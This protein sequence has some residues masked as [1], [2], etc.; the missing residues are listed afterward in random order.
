MTK[1]FRAATCFAVLLAVTAGGCRKKTPLIEDTQ[2]PVPK[3]ETTFTEPE[4]F[5]SIDTSDD[6]SF[7]EADLDEELQRKI[8][9]NLKPVYFEFNS[10]DI[11][12]LSSEN[13]RTAA[14]F[15][16]DNSGMRVLIEG[17]CDERGSSEY[18]MGL[19]ENRAR[20]VKNYLTNYGISSI[21]VEI[22]SWGKERPAIGM[23]AD[24]GCHAQNRRAEFKVLAK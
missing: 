6:A 13:L 21:Q 4:P 17:H 12:G 8:R 2:K 9:E 18:N 24:D 1:F 20:A 11:T 16:S 15:L 14:R 19:G 3:V 5:K 23:C 22:T 7:R 10:Y